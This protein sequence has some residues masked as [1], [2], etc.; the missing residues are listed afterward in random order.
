MTSSLK[1][2]KFSY[3]TV[4]AWYLSLRVNIIIYILLEK[5]AFHLDLQLYWHK[6]NILLQFLIFSI[7]LCPSSFH[8]LF[9]IRLVNPFLFTAQGASSFISFIN[10]TFYFCHYFM[11]LSLLIPSFFKFIFVVSFL[12]YL[13]VNLFH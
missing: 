11:L 5:H 10:S 3:K 1:V 4:W 2:I 6:E 9:L 12:V 7:E 13:V 8:F